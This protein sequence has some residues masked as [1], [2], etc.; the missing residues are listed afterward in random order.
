[1]RGLVPYFEEYDAMVEAN[2]NSRTWRKLDPWERA[3]AVAHYRIKRHI[4]GHENEAVHMDHKRKM[5][6]K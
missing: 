6:I 3:E 2:Y 5:R 4:A 1:M